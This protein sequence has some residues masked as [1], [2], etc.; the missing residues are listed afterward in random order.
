MKAR[1]RTGGGAK[2]VDCPSCGEPGATKWETVGEFD[3]YRCRVCGDFYVSATN[4][5]LVKRE[6]L[7]LR[8]DAAGMVWLTR[9][10]RPDTSR[11]DKLRGAEES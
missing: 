11:T 7:E 10:D 9:P 5:P 1:T 4:R 8:R 2:T 3:A 6:T